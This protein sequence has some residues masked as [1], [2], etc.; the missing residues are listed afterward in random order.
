[1]KFKT[2]KFKNLKATE[3]YDLLRLRSEIFVVEQNCVYLDMD[4]QDENSLHVL[5][6][7]KN[8]KGNGILVGYARI[9]PPNKLYKTP[10]IGRVVVHEK[11]RGKEYGNLLMAKSIKE[12][13]KKFK[14]RVITISAQAHLKNFY[15]KLGFR[16]TGKLYLEDNIPH[17]KM[18]YLNKK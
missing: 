17:I 9:V 5:G 3:L 14:S 11:Y 13:N 6:Y 12:T 2:K 16:A 4:G 1:M 18:L 8:S 10:S 15:G 7:L